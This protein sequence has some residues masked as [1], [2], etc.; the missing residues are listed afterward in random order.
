VNGKDLG[1]VQA[2]AGKA[3]RLKTEF[4]ENLLVEVG[5]K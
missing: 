3:P 1:T 5:G 2:Q 4:K